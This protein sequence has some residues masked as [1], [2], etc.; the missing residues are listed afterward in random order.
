VAALRNR[1][2]RVPGLKSSYYL[3]MALR[4]MAGD[5]WRRPASFNTIFAASE[6]PWLSTG[7]AEQ[8]RFRITLSMMDAD[9]RERFMR[10]V[11]IGC[12]EGIFTQKIADRCESL[13]A[14]DFSAVA[15]SR[16]CERVKSGHVEFRE[17][18]MRSERLPHGPYDLV[19]AMG[20]ITSLY[21]PR[22]VRSTVND[23]IH[24]LEPGGLLLFSD[25]RQSRVFETAWW[26]PLIL[27]GG[28]QI[29]RLLQRSS[30]LEMLGS[31]DT[32]TH[33]F[34]LFRRLSDK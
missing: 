21:R 25:V 33:V 5:Q 12:A 22:D 29:R 23:I 30:N 13:L 16:A 6:D 18:N 2:K 19:I 28:E 34:A 32:D 7:A 1:L 8:E 3:A 26:G 24:A 4:Q 27:R 17:W 20:V 31:A 10:A 11:E 9:G 14:L 15:L